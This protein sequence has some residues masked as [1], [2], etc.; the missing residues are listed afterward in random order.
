MPIV[1]IASRQAKENKSHSTSHKNQSLVLSRWMQTSKV[2][3]LIQWMLHLSP[4]QSV[5]LSVSHLYLYIGVL[6]LHI[7]TAPDSSIPAHSTRQNSSIHR[8]HSLVWN[9]LRSRERAYIISIAIHCHL[10]FLRRVITCH[11]SIVCPKNRDAVQQPEDSSLAVARRE[12]S[13]LA[14]VQQVCMTSVFERSL[15]FLLF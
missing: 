13:S 2:F 7:S 3:F 15:R 12:C 14:M 9:F 11:T 8:M 1:D 4:S 5:R 10:S 6:D